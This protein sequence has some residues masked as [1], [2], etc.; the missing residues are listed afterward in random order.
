MYY[1]DGCSKIENQYKSFLDKSNKDLWANE[2]KSYKAEFESS[3][4]DFSKPKLVQYLEKIYREQCSNSLAELHKTF[5][6]LLECRSKYLYIMMDYYA[7]F[8]DSLLR[9]IPDLDIVQEATNELNFYSRDVNILI[10][11]MNEV[12]W[13]LIPLLKKKDDWKIQPGY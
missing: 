2:F 10:E 5:F 12:S 11:A 3:L 1:L 13:E 9:D 6:Y 7:H 4:G 8:P